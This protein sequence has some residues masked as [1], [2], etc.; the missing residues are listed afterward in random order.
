MRA[1]VLALVLALVIVATAALLARACSRPGALER[2]GG[3]AAPTAWSRPTRVQRRQRSSNI[4]VD[5]LN[6]THWRVDK[7]R[8][9]FGEILDTI[10]S[11]AAPLKARYPGTVV[12]VVKDRDLEF[13]TQEEQAAYRR[14]AADNKVA[15]V[16]VER[17]VDPPS[18]GNNSR[19]HGAK[20]RDDFYMGLLANTYDC[21]VLTNDR[22]RDYTTL[23]H[24]V[25]P[26][27]T[28]EYNY[29]SEY[30]KK[31]FIRPESEGYAKLLRPVVLRPELVF[32][33]PA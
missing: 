3:A 14:A 27:H 13:S 1:L 32:G 9:S 19:E 4:V 10:A 2:V 20:G 11:C 12:F 23:R 28:I 16:V 17:Y 8:I 33:P 15:V 7:K 25:K 31:D 29:W 22:F 18:S 24:H 30:P 6:L 21:A 26:F 5:T